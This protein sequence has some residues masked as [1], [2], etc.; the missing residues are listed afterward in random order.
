VA[1]VVA[2]GDLT[3]DVARQAAAAAT[4]DRLA[5]LHTLTVDLSSVLDVDGVAE[6]V[7]ARVKVALGASA[8]A[9]MLYSEDGLSLEGVGA[10]GYPTDSVDLSVPLSAPVPAVTAVLTGELVLLQSPEESLR[11]GYAQRA[12]HLQLGHGAWAAVPLKT[13]AGVI[14]AIGLSFTGVQVFN[15]D[16]RAFLLVLAAQCAQA[17]ERAQLRSTLD[18]RERQLAKALATLTH[19]API[20]T[21][22][23]ALSTRER[24]VLTLLADGLTNR[25]IAAQLALGIDTV[26]THVDHVCEKLEVSGSSRSRVVAAVRAVRFGLVPFSHRGG[27]A[28]A[29]PR[30][31]AGR[32]L[33]AEP[34]EG[35]M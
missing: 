11:A 3:D 28:L 1:Y 10:T 25:E 24:E 27:F 9:V 2:V 4:A 12:E 22:G 26:K 7:L 14:G 8:A 30:A 16:D 32:K 23:I 5:H 29:A 34:Q 33:D 19:E 21:H 18:H 20:T 6:T 35:R 31:G 13:R 17:I 15:E